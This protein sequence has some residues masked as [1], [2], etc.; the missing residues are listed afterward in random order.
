MV[1]P[2]GAGSSPRVPSNTGEDLDLNL[3]DEFPASQSRGEVGRERAAIR[4]RCVGR[5]KNADRVVDEQAA[6]VLERRSNRL[7]YVDGPFH[8]RLLWS[9]T[10]CLHQGSATRDIRPMTEGYRSY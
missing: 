7:S 8:R 5:P 1:P 10:G 2:C 6:S 3:L 4:S 9:I